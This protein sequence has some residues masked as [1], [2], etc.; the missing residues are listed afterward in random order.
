M[1]LAYITR[2]D[3]TWAQVLFLVAAV[4]AALAVLSTLLRPGLALGWLGAG[5]M[6]CLA[7]G[8]FLAF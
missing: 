8:L 1:T 4:V 6:V 3:L 5:A 7:V 2:P